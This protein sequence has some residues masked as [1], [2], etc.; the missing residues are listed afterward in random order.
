MSSN[1]NHIPN[2][3]SICM[4]SLK[5][6][7]VEL[8]CGHSFHY[9]CLFKWNKEKDNC[10]YCRTH[11][12]ALETNES[13]ENNIPIVGPIYEYLD[14]GYFIKN[15][16][17]FDVE[18]KCKLCKKQLDSCHFCENAFCHCDV[19]RFYDEGSS[20]IYGFNPFNN[21][22]DKKDKKDKELSSCVDCFESREEIL[23]K[24]LFDGDFWDT[25]LNYDIFEDEKLLQIYHTFF[26]NSSNI[27]YID[28]GYSINIYNEYSLEEFKTY[29][30]SIL[31]YTFSYENE[32]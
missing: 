19:T 24:Q 15:K 13:T 17:Q 6:N 26:T 11:I 23:S 29:T 5:T 3:C 22:K 4:E 10:P 28:K 27:D 20:E 14:I 31:N 16:S 21:K 25:N 2:S 1:S 18:F 12:D 32:L 9:S 8:D 30:N 7:K